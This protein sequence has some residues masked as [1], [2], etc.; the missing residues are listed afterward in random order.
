M[1]SVLIDCHYLCHRAF[2]AMKGRLTFDGEQTSVIYGFLTD[3][4]QLR[5]LFN[6]NQLIFCFDSSS[7]LRTKVYPEYKQSR[8]NRSVTEDEEI[9]ETQLRKQIR[10]L[11]TEILPAVGYVNVF[12]ENGYEGDDLLCNVKAQVIQGKNNA[13]VV[14]GDSDLYQL[15]DSRTILYN[16]RTKHTTT[17]LSFLHKYKVHPDQWVMVKAI[18]GCSSDDIA[19]VPGVGEITA[20]KFLKGEM[21][22]DSAKYKAIKNSQHIIDSNL[23]LVELPFAGCPF[24][25]VKEQPDINERVWRNAV[26]KYGIQMNHSKLT[27]RELFD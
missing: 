10:L 25:V 1:T 24:P 19:G 8:R 27:Q 6:T 7:S 16:P 26:R 18:A 15:L 14:T 5:T 11:R 22:K 13:V 17:V 12:C 2:H 23:S 4:Q 20:L 21:K 9:A 3:V